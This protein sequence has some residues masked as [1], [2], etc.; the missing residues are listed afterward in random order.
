LVLLQRKLHLH[1]HV[2]TARCD[3]DENCWQAPGLSQIVFRRLADEGQNGCAPLQVCN[4]EREHWTVC[5]GCSSALFVQ[6]S[7]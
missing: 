2:R 3:Q 7:R 5:R 6:H 1:A 4:A